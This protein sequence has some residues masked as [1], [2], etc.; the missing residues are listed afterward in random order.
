MPPPNKF[1][2][3]LANVTLFTSLFLCITTMV[4]MYFFWKNEESPAFKSRRPI[5][6]LFVSLCIITAMIF[7]NLAAYNICNKGEI[8]HTLYFNLSAAAIYLYSLW[9]ITYRTWILFINWKIAISQVTEI[10]ELNNNENS[11]AVLWENIYKYWA[12]PT[13]I[14][15]WYIVNVI[16]IVII[17]SVSDVDTYFHPDSIGQWVIRCSFIFWSLFSILLLFGTRNMRDHFSLMTEM[18]I[19]IV[20]NVI[21]TCMFIITAEYL[22][23]WA[24][25]Y[26][27]P[28]IVQIKILLNTIR[29]GISSILFLGFPL[30][31]FRHSFNGILL[32]KNLY[33]A[34][35]EAS[36]NAK[37][38][39]KM[40]E[41]EKKLSELVHMDEHI[42]PKYLSVKILETIYPSL[43]AFLSKN[44]KCYNMFKEYLANC[45]AVENI[46]FF[47]EAQKFRLR[48]QRAQQALVDSKPKKQSID[49]D[50]G[51]D[52]N[53]QKE[54]NYNL[55]FWIM[56]LDFF[57]LQK[58][59]G[60]EVETTSLKQKWL[61]IYAQFIAPSSP[62]QINI[63]H[64]QFEYLNAFKQRMETDDI[65]VDEYVESFENAMVQIWHLMRKLYLHFQVTDEYKK[66]ITQ[67]FQ[68]FNKK[69]K[70][71]IDVISMTSKG[72]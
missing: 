17:I 21:I 14:R 65:S 35:V 48:V 6:T 67:Y 34:G 56:R 61:D 41:K 58:L 31:K 42:D 62:N 24:P 3:L 23:D 20:L 68:R 27:P 40:T 70:D 57:Y 47:T 63:S 33:T 11:N 54:I 71:S 38:S 45:L 22:S 50:D 36:K 49:I 37:A 28:Q 39:I 29:S 8:Q 13:A 18:K 66:I 64:E 19:Y 15:C 12:T 44:T 26:S 9:L 5:M 1:C 30:F 25:S 60:L 16:W 46:L 59:G 53:N 52:A 4:L 43:L 10:T 69:N 2:P 72:K 55:Q 51:N 7:P 32:D